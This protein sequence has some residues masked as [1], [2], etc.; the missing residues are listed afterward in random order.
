MFA[1]DYALTLDEKNRL[2][3][4]A[5]FRSFIA[6]SDREGLFLL[7]RPTRTERCLR[8]YPATYM[9]KV[10]LNIL[11]EAGKVE[12]PEEFLRAVMPQMQ[13]TPLDSQ[14][15]FVVPQKLVDYAGLGRE[16][17]MVGMTEW[18]EVWDPKEYRVASERSR[19]KYKD[20]LGR[21]LWAEGS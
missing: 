1:G 7:V 14:G 20:R 9:Q 21:V 13:F 11:R 15:R 3:I 10:K 12:D 6:A 4:P 8:A 2:V 5:M 17:L 19:E 16:V 18:I